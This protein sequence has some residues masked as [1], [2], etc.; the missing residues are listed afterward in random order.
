M[1]LPKFIPISIVGRQA[2]VVFRLGSKFQFLKQVL[3]FAHWDSDIIWNLYL[4]FEI[5][6][7]ASLRRN[8]GLT[9]RF[10]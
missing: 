6:I 2:L 3:N 10:T 9:S 4:E 8:L 5:S 7:I 1:K